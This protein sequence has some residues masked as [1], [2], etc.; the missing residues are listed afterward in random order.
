MATAEPSEPVQGL[1]ERL[2]TAP[3]RSSR[4]DAFRRL[5]DLYS[6]RLYH[7]FSRRGFPHAD[8]LD[9][10]QE[11]FL[12]IYKGIG[13][14][15][16]DSSFETWLFKIA[17]NAYR[18]R[19]RWG[20]AG[21]RDAPEV[22]LEESPEEGGGAM[23]TLAA[24]D[25][26]APGEEMLRRERSLVLRQAIDRLPEQM[27]KCLVLRVDHEMKYKEIAAVLRLSPETVKVHLAHARRRLQE[28]LGPYFEGSL[29]RLEEGV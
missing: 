27:R 6:P 7:F 10:T 14:F 20:V 13:A 19:L 9:L 25:V 28:E 21:K 1:I 3:A 18:K 16:R 22:P 26:P 2:Q 8:C 17:T 29:A 24:T 11:T 23:A 12:G 5:F 15:R 4:D